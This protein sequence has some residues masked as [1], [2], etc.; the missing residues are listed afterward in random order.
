MKYLLGM[1]ELSVHTER[2][3]GSKNF[4]TIGASD[5]ILRLRVSFLL[6]I[7][8]GTVDEILVVVQAHDFPG[9]R[10]R[11][12]KQFLFPSRHLGSYKN[13]QALFL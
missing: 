8:F 5:R 4:T 1:P 11:T 12:T 6:G 13:F 3:L 9:H 10:I 7:L 2:L